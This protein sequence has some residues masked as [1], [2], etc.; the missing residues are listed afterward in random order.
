MFVAE[1]TRGVLLE[2]LANSTQRR[3]AVVVIKSGYARNAL[4]GG[5]AASAAGAGDALLYWI[6]TDG[7]MSRL[8]SGLASDSKSTLLLDLSTLSPAS[9]APTA[10]AV[11]KRFRLAV[12]L[13]RTLNTVY[14]VHLDTLETAR[15]AIPSGSVAH[16]VT[17][18]VAG[19]AV[20]VSL[21]VGNVTQ[22]ARLDSALSSIAEIVFDQRASPCCGYVFP[23]AVETRGAAG[24]CGAGTYTSACLPCP[25]GTFSASPLNKSC[26]LCSSD[27]YC[28]VAA[29][30]PIPRQLAVNSSYTEV[31]LLQDAAFGDSSLPIIFLFAYIGTVVAVTVTFIVVTIWLRSWRYETIWPKYKRKC[32][33]MDVC[34]RARHYNETPAVMIHRKSV[35]GA[36]QTLLFPTLLIML[37]IYIGES[38]CFV[39]VFANVAQESTGTRLPSLPVRWCPLATWMLRLRSK[40]ASSCRQCFGAFPECATKALSRWQ[41][42]E[43]RCPLRQT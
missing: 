39:S 34:F 5:L 17:L 1:E 6:T 33:T 3:P 23:L 27:E 13:D 26:T 37:A 29:A 36:F 18:D 24:L 30:V 31:A 20:F 25:E 40:A 22:I 32:Q 8:F 21:A 42:R 4:V 35:I 9:R 28:S 16:S 2:V 15:F 41:W 38:N 10:L 7:D 12:W 43:L 14:R 19:G 11:S